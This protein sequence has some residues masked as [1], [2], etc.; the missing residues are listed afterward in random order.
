M[1]LVMLAVQLVLLAAVIKKK[2]IEKEQRPAPDHVGIPASAHGRGNLKNLIT[3]TMS[4]CNRA[5]QLHQGMRD[6]RSYRRDR[7]LAFQG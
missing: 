5:W 4:Q 1:L 6:P 2:I 7:H 3:T